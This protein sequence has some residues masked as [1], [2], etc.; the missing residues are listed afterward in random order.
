MHIGASI[1]LYLEI[2]SIAHTWPNARTDKHRPSTVISEKMEDAAKK[3]LELMYHG[4]GDM[5]AE[6]TG[7][8]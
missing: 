6:R 7:E 3:V 2:F 8:R 1:G 4:W 5:N